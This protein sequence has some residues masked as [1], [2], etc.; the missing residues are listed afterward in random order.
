MKHCL[1]QY[2]T[3]EVSAKLIGRENILPSSSVRAR[4][5]KNGNGNEMG[6]V[7]EGRQII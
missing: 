6:V 1:L 7:E 5:Q 3:C 4:S 2:Q